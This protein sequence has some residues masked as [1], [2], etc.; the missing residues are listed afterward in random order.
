MKR[1]PLQD[2]KTFAPHQELEA[3]L[4]EKAWGGPGKES[5]FTPRQTQQI[6]RE[7]ARIL[8][9]ETTQ[10]AAQQEETL[11]VVEF[12]LARERYA[13]EAVFVRSVQQAPQLTPLPCTPAFVLGIMNV[14]GRILSVVDLRTFFDLPPISTAHR[15]A[16][17]IL[18]TGKLELGVLIDE[19]LGSWLL[20]VKSVKAVAP[21]RFG[22]RREYLRGI[23][24]ER[25][26][27]LD[28]ER[29]LSDKR[30]IVGGDEV[31]L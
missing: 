21:G 7:R 24:D 6:L 12:S 14:H 4:A 25:V 18:R 29:I 16:V 10:D 13:V 26:I 23:V 5:T 22:I 17:V 20:P 2:S 15:E 1:E 8:A 31:E 3:P 27:V 11:R 30:M 19:V 9:K 28:V